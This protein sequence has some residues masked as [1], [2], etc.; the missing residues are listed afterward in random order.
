MADII[1]GPQPVPTDPPTSPELLAQAVLDIWDER[2]RARGRMQD[3]E[4]Q[5]CLA[6]AANL[7]LFGHP[8]GSE[9]IGGHRLDK[10]TRLQRNNHITKFLNA[11]EEH[12]PP[13]PKDETGRPLY[14][15]AVGWNDTTDDDEVLRSAVEKVTHADG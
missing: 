7:A 3:D 5:C 13:S 8:I 11:V 14:F 15:S 4:G 6:G 1:E 2:G 9:V 10:V 12:M